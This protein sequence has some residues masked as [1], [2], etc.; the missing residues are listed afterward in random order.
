MTEKRM[1][2]VRGRSIFYDDLEGSID[3]AIK[4]FQVNL[5]PNEKN[6]I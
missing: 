4:K 3:E 5:L 2:Q 1:I 6:L